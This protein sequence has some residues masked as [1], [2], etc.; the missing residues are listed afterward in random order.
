MAEKREILLNPSYT[1]TKVQGDCC[2]APGV[3]FHAPIR[4]DQMKRRAPFLLTPSLSPSRLK[5][6]LMKEQR[7]ASLTRRL[8]T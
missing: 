7:V 2:A 4:S 6:G 5:E 3:S 1:L 8:E